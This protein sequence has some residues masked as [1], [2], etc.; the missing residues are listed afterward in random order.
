[1][2]IL[3]SF[4]HKLREIDTSF[5]DISLIKNWPFYLRKMGSHVNKN[6]GLKIRLNHQAVLKLCTLYQNLV[7]N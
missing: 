2:K 1:M 7:V 6:K 4:L 5:S 3:N